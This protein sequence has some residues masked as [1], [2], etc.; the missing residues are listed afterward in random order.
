MDGIQ[1]IEQ[2]EQLDIE[3]VDPGVIEKFLQELPEKAFH[4]GLRIVLAI[5]A[6]LIGMQLIRL[7]R[8]VMKRGLRRGKVEENAIHFIDSFVKYALC[9]VLII[10]IASWMGVDATSIVAILGSASVAIGLALQGSL[11]N[12]AGGI[13]LLCLKPFVV[14]DYI[15]DAQG[16]E[17]TVT[18]I[19][20]FYTRLHTFDDKV[21]VLPNGTLANGS[22]INYTKSEKR[23]VDIP[24]GIAYEEDIRKAREVLMTMIK[25]DEDVLKKETMRVVVDS[26]A[27]SSV[28]LVIHCW[29]KSE[30][31]WPVKWRLTEMPSMRWMM[32][33]LP[34]PFHSL[35][36][37]QNN[38]CQNKGLPL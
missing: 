4:L 8:S 15:M 21:I 23:R 29:C 38:S 31:Y 35:I 25:G 22:I 14:G 13:L 17:G 3:N 27:D 34:Y 33:V 16:M 24:V 28:N 11:S 12:M 32:Q 6:L 18:A 37:I 20:V 1:Q 2:I 19:D 10:F 9:F 5:L 30:D 26:L 36:F 7:V